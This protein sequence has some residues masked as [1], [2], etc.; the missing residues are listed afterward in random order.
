MQ[1]P[2]NIA[3]PQ[4]ASTMLGRRDEDGVGLEQKGS[5]SE[6]K[7]EPQCRPTKWTLG[8]K[9]RL[10]IDIPKGMTGQ[11]FKQEGKPAG[12]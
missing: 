5:E 3:L 8:G 1:M 4:R 12:S 11:K 2:G 10:G 9:S 6:Q 7:K